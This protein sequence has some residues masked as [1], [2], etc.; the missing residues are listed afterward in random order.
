[1]RR[2]YTVVWIAWQGDLLPGDDRLVLDV[3]VARHPTT[4]IRGTVYSEFIVDE[5]GQRVMPLSGRV[6]VRSYPVLSLDK[7]AVLFTQQRDAKSPAIAISPDTWDFAR[8]EKGIGVDFRTEEHAIIPSNDHIRLKN[9]FEPGWIYRL[10]YQSTDPLVLGLGQV[11]VRDVV[12]FLK[13]RDRDDSGAPNPLGSGST[14]KAYAWG[15]SQS[16][17]AIRD[18]IYHGLNDKNGRRI[19]DGVIIN[20]SG[21]GRLAPSRYA[22]LNS[23]GSQQYEDHANPSD[24]YPFAYVPCTEPSTGQTDAILK[25]PTSDPFVIHIQT[26]SEYWQRRGSLVHTSSSGDD[27]PEAKNLRLFH[28][29]SSQHSSDP[30]ALQP[31]RGRFENLQNIVQ[32]SFFFRVLLDALDAWA[33]NGREPPASLLPRRRDGTLLPFEVWRSAFPRIPGVTLPL[34][35]NTHE[36]FPVFVPA[37]DQDGNEIAGVHAPMVA[38]PLGTYTGWNVRA[39]GYGTGAMHSLNGSYIPFPETLEQARAD[40]DP[41]RSILQRYGSAEAYTAAI[42]DAAM[43]LVSRGLMLQEDVERIVKE[44]AR[45]GRPRHDV[46]L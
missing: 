41:R 11:V 21:A 33:T 18:F 32:T 29:A 19:F 28:W 38:V 6:S 4:P 9:G 7:S 20:A 45:W 30:T 37:T 3:P 42:K 40:G 16:G 26:S 39:Q 36:T 35:A 17:R 2:G 5:P 12:D 10:R 44:A 22:N 46:Q 31:R 34:N 23:P 8:E 43:D 24:I 25:R 27:L 14:E 13:Y 1:M 15:R